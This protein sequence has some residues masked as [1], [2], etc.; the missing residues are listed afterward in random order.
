MQ[1]W[2]ESGLSVRAFC[3]AN[4]VPPHRVWYWKK[5]LAT[6]DGA[7]EGPR[8]AFVV[9]SSADIDSDGGGVDEGE[10]S[11]GD[12]TDDAVE[13]VLG[14]GELIRIP[15]GTASLSEIFS[16]VRGARR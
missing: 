14:D 7:D 5:R 9:L 2:R 15:C 4:G 12:A 10:M 8:Q 16:A 1:R 3:E 13:V 11:E 6:S